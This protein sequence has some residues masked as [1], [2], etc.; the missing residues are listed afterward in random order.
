MNLHILGMAKRR[1]WRQVWASA[2]FA[3]SN[4]HLAAIKT[5]HDAA[6]STFRLRNAEPP[7]LKV[8]YKYASW[9]GG[10]NLEPVDKAAKDDPKDKPVDKRTLK[11]VKS[12]DR[13]EEFCWQ[14]LHRAIDRFP[15]GHRQ[16]IR[17]LLAL[18]SWQKVHDQR[19]AEWWRR[20]RKKLPANLRRIQD[21]AAFNGEVHYA[22]GSE[23]MFATAKAAKK[24][25]A[26][27]EETAAHSE[28]MAWYQSD[29]NQS[30]MKLFDVACGGLHGDPRPE[31]WDEL[32]RSLK[33]AEQEVKNG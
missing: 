28:S 7:A 13:D 8:V 32:E 25:Q 18:T 6:W 15:D 11:A 30:L 10:V 16:K 24:Y 33:A 20:G 31:V 3:G 19:W 23:R 26:S 5:Y 9:E 17:A 14:E 22:A 4:T 2:A 27:S 29:T 1:M 21:F 12:L